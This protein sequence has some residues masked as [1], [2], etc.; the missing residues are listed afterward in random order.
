MMRQELKHLL[1][2]MD[3]KNISFKYDNNNLYIDNPKLYKSG[4][5]FNDRLYLFL[6]LSFYNKDISYNGIP[7]LVHPYE[8][9]EKYRFDDVIHIVLED[10][11]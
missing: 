11:R 10:I 6:P 3:I 1:K 2:Q 9:S 4:I 5:R 7:C 8:I